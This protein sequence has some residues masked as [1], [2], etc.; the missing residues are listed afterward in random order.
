MADDGRALED[1]AAAIS[2]LT[3]DLADLQSTVL[4]RLASRPTGDIEMTIRTTAKAGT[5][6]CSGQTLNRADYPGLWAWI[7]D[8]SLSGSGKPFGAGN[9]TTT[10]VM[11][12]WRGKVPR[13][14]AATGEVIGQAT[15]ADSITLSIAQLPS[16]GHS[17]SVNNH[18]NH[19]HG[20]ITAQDGAHGGHFPGSQFT[21]AAGADYGL[22]AW[23]SGGV[24]SGTHN[25][26]FATDS[27]SVSAHVVNQSNVGSGNTVDI[28]QAGFAVNWLI[29]I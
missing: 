6:L 27:Q 11:P 19:S 10:F 16:H 5:L 15:G 2:R 4:A 23:N 22:A 17:V 14:L 7:T 28:R 9:G 24:G 8:Q 20:G 18:S 25:H 29:Y 1:P 21:A 12:D 13:G 26:G 3:A